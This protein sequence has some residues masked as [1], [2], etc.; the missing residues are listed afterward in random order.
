M[1][2]TMSTY[3]ANALLN[4][5]RGGA[6]YTP[7]TN[8]YIAAYTAAPTKAGGGTEVAGNGYIRVTIPYGAA[9]DG[10]MENSAIVAFAAASGGN[11]GDIVAYGVFDAI[12]GGNFLGFATLDN[13]PVTINDGDILRF[14]IGDLAFGID[15]VA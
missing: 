14:P 4:H 7:P 3:L 8:L 1:A 10:L 2:G 13:S 9:S 5:V 12:S 6:T 11:W 15:Q